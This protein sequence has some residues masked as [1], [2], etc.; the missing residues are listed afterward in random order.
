MGSMLLEVASANVAIASEGSACQDVFQYFGEVLA[1]SVRRERQRDS[2]NCCRDIIQDEFIIYKRL[3]M[4]DPLI[5][6]S[7]GC[8]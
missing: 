2:Q 1:G 3:S 7:R 6:I 8:S 4:R 5:L